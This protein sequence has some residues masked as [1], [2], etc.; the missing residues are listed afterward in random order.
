MN[1]ADPTHSRR[2]LSL[3][4]VGEA[5]ARSDSEPGAARTSQQ[6][7][8]RVAEASGPGPS[9]SLRITTFRPGPLTNQGSNISV[10][11][12]KPYRCSGCKW[13]SWTVQPEPGAAVARPPDNRPNY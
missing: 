10:C 1:G 5:A 3:A 6:R 13:R 7:A 9:S 2:G 11:R 12:V 4:L 8:G